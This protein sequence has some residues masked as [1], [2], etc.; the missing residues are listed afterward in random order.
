[1]KAC[2]TDGGMTGSPCSR[3]VPVLARLQLSALVCVPPPPGSVACRPAS[4]DCGSSRCSRPTRLIAIAAAGVGKPVRLPTPQQRQPGGRLLR[5]T[6]A[7]QVVFGASAAQ[8]RFRYRAIRQVHSPNRPHRRCRCTASSTYSERANSLA[9]SPAKGQ[10]TTST[11]ARSPARARTTNRSRRQGAATGRCGHCRSCGGQRSTAGAAV[12]SPVLHS[13]TAQGLPRA[14]GLWPHQRDRGGIGQRRERAPTAHLAVPGDLFE[15]KE[16][17]A[18]PVHP[19]F[20][21]A[22]SGSHD[23]AVARSAG[24]APKSTSDAP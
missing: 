13:S 11:P 23:T 6:P 24:P 15:E 9:V 3:S 4:V 22:T 12:G 1:V 10:A 16:D 14:P 7:S 20:A 17:A 8:R 5:H 2:H 19:G 18:G 21:A